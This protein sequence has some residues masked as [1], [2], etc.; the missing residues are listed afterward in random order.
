MLQRRAEALVFT[1]FVLICSAGAAIADGGWILTAADFKQRP[2]VLHSI[3]QSGV[4][5]AGGADGAQLTAFDDFIQMEREVQPRPGYAMLLVL[6][7]GDRLAGEPIGYENEQ[8]EWK[9]EQ[10]GQMQIPLKR[11]AAIARISALAKL[12]Q[13]PPLEDV[14]HL[15]NGD[16]A[17]GII[18]SF[19]SDHV[20]ISSNGAGIEIPLA[21]TDWIR[22]AQTAQPQRLEGVAFRLRLTDGSM[23]TAYSLVSNE[24][25][26]EAELPGGTTRH[27]PLA[28]IVGI[29]QL[30]GP[31]SWLSSRGWQAAIQRPYIGQLTWPTNIDATVTGRAILADGRS[32]LRGLGVHAYSRIDYE[33]EG[34]YGAFRTSYAIAADEPNPYADVT[35]R[36]LVDDQPVHEQQHVRFGESYA[37]VTVDLPEGA[38]QLSLVADYGD[39]NDTQDRLNWIEPALIRKR[40]PSTAP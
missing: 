26:L 6:L 15:A 11:I 19:T 8:V 13:E 4:R 14:V 39:G 30:N 35:V 7:N 38:K 16:V 24:K 32:N 37:P 36:I 2:V 29:E 1:A 10:L 20:K 21:S 40:Q 28:S 31:V 17:K 3:D 22:L 33:L 5:C 27:I 9:N 18:T 25:S 34:A 12:P 23:I